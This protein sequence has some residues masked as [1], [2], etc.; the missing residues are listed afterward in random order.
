MYFTN[1]TVGKQSRLYHNDR[2]RTFENVYVWTA[3]HPSPITP[4][5]NV[6]IRNL[7]IDRCAD[8]S[9]CIDTNANTILE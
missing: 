2:P 9:I 1:I 4:P 7:K 8:T 6:R 3:S 5:A